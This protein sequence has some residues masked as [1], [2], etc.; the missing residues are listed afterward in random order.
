M[1]KHKKARVLSTKGRSCGFGEQSQALTCFGLT[2]VAQSE[3]DCWLLRHH[4]QNVSACPAVF[5]YEPYD[6]EVMRIGLVKVIYFEIYK[7]VSVWLFPHFLKH[8]G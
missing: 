1:Q 2:F 5:N 8:T 3:R 4:F 6:A 7:N